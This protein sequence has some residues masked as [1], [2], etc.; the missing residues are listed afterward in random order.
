MAYA[1]YLHCSFCERDQDAGK[2]GPHPG[3]KA[4]Y[5]GDHEGVR[6]GIEVLCAMHREALVQRAVDA[7]NRLGDVKCERDSL[8]EQLADMTKMRDV[9]C[10]Q[11]EALSEDWAK[12]DADLREAIALLREVQ[13]LACVQHGLHW[14]D[15]LDAFL[16]KH[17]EQP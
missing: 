17:K 1:N 12:A 4:V 10:E 2:S 14:S 3:V 7:E 11:L 15:K 5:V 8:I 9:A 16:A 6:E 13:P